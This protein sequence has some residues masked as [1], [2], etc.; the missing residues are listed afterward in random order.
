MFVGLHM[1]VAV[2]AQQFMVHTV[3]VRGC[4]VEGAQCG[5]KLAYE[6]WEFVVETFH[7]DVNACVKR[8]V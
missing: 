7:L 1:H 5:H 3:V 6:D 2:L 8:G 4:W